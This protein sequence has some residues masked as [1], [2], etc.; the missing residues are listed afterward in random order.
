MNDDHC[1]TNVTQRACD[2]RHKGVTNWLTT[3]L[4]IM[5][6]TLSSAGAA[7]VTARGAS[8]DVA[9]QTAAQ[10]EVNTRVLDSLKRIESDVRILRNGH[11][12]E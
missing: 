1:P 6:A 5:V 9:V 10:S 8:Q 12:H 4:I 2:A 7:Y 3:V 11:G